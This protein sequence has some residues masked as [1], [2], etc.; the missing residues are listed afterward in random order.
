MYGMFAYIWV[1]L[2]ANVGKYSI[3]GAI[4]VRKNHQTECHSDHFDWRKMGIPGYDML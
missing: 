2:K 1:I 4:W 3:Y